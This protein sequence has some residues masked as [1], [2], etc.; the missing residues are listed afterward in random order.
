MR[1]ENRISEKKFD[2][3]LLSRPAESKSILFKEKKS[4]LNLGKIDSKMDGSRLDSNVNRLEKEIKNR[5]SHS[6]PV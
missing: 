6:S 4:E 2:D 1:G 5:T 3:F